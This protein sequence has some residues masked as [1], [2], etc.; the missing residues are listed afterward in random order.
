MS[1]GRPPGAMDGVAPRV[2]PVAHS[3]LLEPDEPPP[4][5]RRSALQA[6]PPALLVCDHAS[7]RV[8]RGLGELGLPPSELL[9]HIGWDIGAAEVTTALAELLDLPAVFSGYS[10]L[11]I[12]CNRHPE[13]PAA[14]PE[15]SDGTWVPG[16]AGLTSRQRATRR[17]ALFDPYHR[18]VGEGLGALAAAR[19]APLLVA[20]HSFTP[21]MA[22]RARPWH[23]GVL[24]D[25]DDRVAAPLLAG[26]RRDPALRVGDNQPYSGRSP[27]GFTVGW[28][29]GRRGLP[30]VALEIRQDLIATPGGVEACARLLAA[31]L[32]PILRAA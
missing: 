10:R 9:R 24:W 21:V 20:V 25:T 6:A 1:P 12:D 15:T 28:H 11:V 32:Q 3:G 31:A 22:G 5:R 19:A 7:W 29:A 26:L 14:I 4:A 30:H 18:A 23:V 8:P 17:E 27:V 16:N 2:T 13:D